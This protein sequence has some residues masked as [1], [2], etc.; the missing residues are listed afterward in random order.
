MM[1]IQTRVG[2]SDQSGSGNARITGNTRCSQ[3]NSPDC[4]TDLKMSSLENAGEPDFRI[5]SNNSQPCN[6]LSHSPAIFIDLKETH[7]RCGIYYG[8][9][10]VANQ[11]V[12][13]RERVFQK[14]IF[15]DLDPEQVALT[16]IN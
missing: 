9:T 15:T 10:L 2:D 8:P 16:Y 6:F 13:V 3:I 5:N 1:L 12:E 11:W 7:L 14:N 4:L